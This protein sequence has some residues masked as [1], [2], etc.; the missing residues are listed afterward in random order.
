[1]GFLSKIFAAA[2]PR[3]LDWAAGKFQDWIISI[4]N[5]GIE[6]DA[7]EKKAKLEQKERD[8]DVARKNQDLD[9]VRNL[10][11]TIIGLQRKSKPR[12]ES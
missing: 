11:A 6:K 12:D 10:R 8:L 9:R 7:T 1:M 5:K 2:L 3:L 4:Q